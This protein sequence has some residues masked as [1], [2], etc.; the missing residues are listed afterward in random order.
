MI[1]AIL[2]VGATGFSLTGYGG[3]KEL[4]IADAV[5][6]SPPVVR[7]A[8]AVPPQG[9]GQEPVTAQQPPTAFGGAPVRASSD[10]VA[11]L[12]DAR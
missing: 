8:P 11:T 10:A 7:P 5:L 9:A 3:F 12:I 4:G 2:V 6:L 1:A